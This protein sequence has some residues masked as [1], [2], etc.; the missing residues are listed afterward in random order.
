MSGITSVS[1]ISLNIT[2]YIILVLQ[3]VD[4]DDCSD[5]FDRNV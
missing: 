5:Y 1:A 2:R 4:V 3:F